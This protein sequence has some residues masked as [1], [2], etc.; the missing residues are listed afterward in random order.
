MVVGLARGDEARIADDIVR[1]HHSYIASA[2]TVGRT[3]KYLVWNE[4]VAV[5]TVWI[6]SGMKPTPKDLLRFFGVSQP[7]FDG[8]FN[9][10]ADNKR[11]C[12]VDRTPNLGSYVLARV[13]ERVRHDWT[14]AYGD[15][16][17]AV[18]TTVGPS[19]RGSVYLADNWTQIGETAG[20][21]AIRKPVS[22]KWNKASEINERFVKPTGENRKKIFVTTRLGSKVGRQIV[23]GGSEQLLLDLKH[24]LDPLS[25]PETTRP[26]RSS[27][28]QYRSPHGQPDP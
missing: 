21:P 14:A 8:F 12:M 7:E 25:C 1:R 15:E 24:P 5:G 16:L 11:F 18:F 22:M 19:H 3:L 6:G 23:T 10:V 2:Q 28:H 17:R 4:G 20:L 26:R 27:G 13:R 9:S